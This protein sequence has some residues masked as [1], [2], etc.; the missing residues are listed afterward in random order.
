MGVQGLLAGILALAISGCSA[1]SASERSASANPYYSQTSE[2]SGLG[3]GFIPVSGGTVDLFELDDVLVT[4]LQAFRTTQGLGT[5]NRDPLLDQAAQ[6]LADVMA[7]KDNLSHQADGQRAG[8]RIEDTGYV[9]CTNGSPWAENIARSSQ[10]GSTADVADIMMTGWINSPGHRRNMVG[11]FA[12]VGL[13]VA[14]T[15]DGSRVYAAQVFATP[16]PGRCL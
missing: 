13:A 12:E 3:N 1:T 16:G 7:R 6:T 15:S 4:E 8:D 14:E 9:L 2:G 5:L 11:A 10:F